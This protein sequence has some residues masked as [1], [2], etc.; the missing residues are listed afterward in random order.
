MEDP[1]LALL[2]RVAT[3][4]EEL[5]DLELDNEFLERELAEA[6][7]RIAYL[8]REL[9]MQVFLKTTFWNYCNNLLD[10]CN[11][12]LDGDLHGVDNA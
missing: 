6:C 7:E 4:A 8:E 11:S 2:E 3:V 10:R 12:L 9:E 5:Q 1:I